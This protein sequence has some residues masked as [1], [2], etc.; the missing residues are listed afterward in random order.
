VYLAPNFLH[1]DSYARALAR[2]CRLSAVDIINIID[3]HLH[4]NLM[5]GKRAS[6]D[7][8]SIRRTGVT[9]NKISDRVLANSP[10]SDEEYS[11]DRVNDRRAFTI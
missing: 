11:F 4:A 9:S 10:P 6:Q 5:R 3:V 2:I 8:G 1:I 7:A